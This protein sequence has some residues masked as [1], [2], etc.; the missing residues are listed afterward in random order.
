MSQELDLKLSQ[1]L[2]FD[3]KSAVHK[4]RLVGL[5][6]VLTGYRWLYFGAMIAIVLGAFVRV[7]YYRVVQYVI[8]TVVDAGMN[9]QQLPWLGLSFVGLAVLEGLFAY[10][11]GVWSAETAEG[12]ALRLRNYLYDHIQRLPFAFHDYQDR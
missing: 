1:K 10:L 6:R 8:D 12:I 4:N 9:P 5:W 3:L 11:R 2:T 7:Y